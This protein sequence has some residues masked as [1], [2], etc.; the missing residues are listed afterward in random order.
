M[1]IT[2]TPIDD[3]YSVIIPSSWHGKIFAT[4]V[5]PAG[6]YNAHV[7]TDVSNTRFAMYITDADYVVTSDVG[8][9]SQSGTVDKQITLT[10]KGRIV[11]FIGTDSAL[12]INVHDLQVE[13]GSSFT[14]YH[15]YTGD[16]IS[17]NWENEAGTVYGGTLTLNPDRTGTL[18]V[19]RAMV[20]LGTLTWAVKYKSVY[21]G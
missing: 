7:K 16:Q 12:T 5:L 10:E 3:G 2:A 17:V 6:N 13:S 19:D 8:R 15:P 9:I 14:S 1:A 18:V 21:R 20:D 11:F 4:D